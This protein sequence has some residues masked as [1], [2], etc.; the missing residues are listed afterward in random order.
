MFRERKKK[1]Y[2]TEKLPC[3]HTHNQEIPVDK[4]FR[5]IACITC[6][7]VYYPKTVAKF[8]N[9]KTVER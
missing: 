6:G 3:G 1:F 9:W 2:K 7:L 4:D 5:L 8:M